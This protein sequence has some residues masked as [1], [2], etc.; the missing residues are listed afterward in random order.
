LT[1][2]I[3]PAVR[4][5]VVRTR[6]GRV[7]EGDVRFEADAVKVIPK[8][9]AGGFTLMFK[10]SDVAAISV[11]PPITGVLSGGTLAGGWSVADVGDTS[12]AGS[13]DYDQGAF[14]LRGE[15]TRFGHKSDDFLC[16]YQRLP[17]DGQ[18][19]AR[20]TSLSPTDPTAFAGLIIRHVLA[21]ESRYGMMAVTAGEGAKFYGKSSSDLTTAFVTPG[22]R[23]K[24]PCW[25]KIVKIGDTVIG[26]QSADGRKWEFVGKLVMEGL[27]D[28]Y[29]GLAVSSNKPGELAT[30][31]FDA[32]QA[33]IHGLKAEY[34]GDERFT[35]LRLS[36]LDTSIDFNWG[37]DPPYTSMPADGYTVRWTGQI[38][39]PATD[40]YRFQFRGNGAARLWINGALVYD[41]RHSGVV[42]L[43]AN[44][45]YD[46]RMDFFKPR[47]QGD[48]HLLW[49]TSTMP[50][51]PVPS[52]NLYYVPEVS[53]AASDPALL[54]RNAPVARGVLLADGTFLPGT[55]TEAD[56]QSLTLQYK[57]REAMKL[58]NENVAR[59]LFR[60]L[61]PAAAAKI[62]AKGTGLLTQAGD[63]VE[64]DLESIGTGKVQLSSIV[65]GINAYD[66]EAQAAALILRETS[67]TPPAFIVHTTS[68]GTFHFT[69]L[70]GEDG[71]LIGSEAVLGDF[72]LR[73]AE[74]IDVTAG[75][76]VR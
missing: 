67:P 16:V 1:A 18:L 65:F 4:A 33:T 50:E 54:V 31:T 23:L 5:G 64:G 52:E 13:A 51:A 63:F 60:P 34:Y 37:N 36:R 75:P 53:T 58:S 44:K 10:F 47:G 15:G 66:L 12:V 41:T 55:V 35:D 26:A 2:L 72:R 8:D 45:R 30:A 38:E 27:R 73:M 48:C 70:K 17:G 7:Y 24:P 3:V 14:T 57:Q 32:V 28:A 25:L 29:V 49:S 46:L 71:D 68:G 43:V 6:D 11:K 40:T 42:S 21:P 22:A 74:I 39:A 19:V 62:P 69:N 61:N 20:V 59:V 76:G 56:R 9:G